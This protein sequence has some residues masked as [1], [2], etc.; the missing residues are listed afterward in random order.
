MSTLS[1][2]VL[3]T[4]IGSPAPALAVRLE[5]PKGDEW[6]TV[7]NG[8]TDGDGRYRFDGEILVGTYR[9]VFATGEYLRASDRDVFYPLVS[10]EFAVTDADRHYHVAL[11]LS[12]YGYTTYRGS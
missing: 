12:T 10:I 4:T 5:R 2:H 9:M 8:V 1:T 3:D 6:E 7:E 11:L